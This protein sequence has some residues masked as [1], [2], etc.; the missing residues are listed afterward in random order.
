MPRAVI[1]RAEWQVGI[2]PPLTSVVFG[3][4]AIG[5]GRRWVGSRGSGL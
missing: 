1:K 2:R 3:G 4:L 5:L